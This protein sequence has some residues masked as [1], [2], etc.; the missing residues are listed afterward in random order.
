MAS[1]I[2]RGFVILADLEFATG[3]SQLSEG[4]Y[5]SLQELADVL[6]ERTDLRVALVGH[7]DAVGVLAAN[8]A[9]SRARAQAVRT[10][11]IEEYGIEASRLDAEG[12]AYLGPIASNLTPEGRQRN[13]RVEAV[14]LNTE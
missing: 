8:L 12:I 3:T 6:L 1:L 14:L 2:E 5:A 10:R 4:R 7:T 13:R 11:L 9:L